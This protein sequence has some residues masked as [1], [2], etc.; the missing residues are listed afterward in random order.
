RCRTRMLPAVTDSPPYRLMPSRW[1]CDSRPLRT[2]PCPF[3]CAML[4]SGVA[5]FFNPNQPRAPARR[6]LRRRPGLVR[7]HFRGRL[8]AAHLIFF[9]R[10]RRHVAL[11]RLRLR[12]LPD[13]L[14]PVDPFA[15][16]LETDLARVHVIAVAEPFEVQLQGLAAD[17]RRPV[18]V[19]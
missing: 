3:L 5:W 13:A 8:S 2:E 15:R 6:S 10:R 17:R 16:R 14:G 18:L 1:L 12:G 9:R 4:S 7:D 11:R 19:L